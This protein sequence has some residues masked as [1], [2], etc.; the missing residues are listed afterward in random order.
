[1][2][3]YQI[4]ALYT[5]DEGHARWAYAKDGRLDGAALSPTGVYVDDQLQQVEVDSFG[6][7][8]LVPQGREL[9]YE[10][11]AEFAKAEDAVLFQQLKEIE[12]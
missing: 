8:K 3:S 9:V 7:Y 6:V 12:Q 11:V 5:D 4:K 1:M 2:N 10:W